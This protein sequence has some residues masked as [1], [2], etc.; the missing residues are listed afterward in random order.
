MGGIGILLVLL[1]L[2]IYIVKISSSSSGSGDTYRYTGPATPMPQPPEPDYILVA[3]KAFVV[4]EMSPTG[5]RALLSRLNVE[6]KEADEVVDIAQ[7]V[8]KAWYAREQDTDDAT[9]MEPVAVLQHIDDL[10]TYP[11]RKY[12]KPGE[13]Y[14]DFFRMLMGK[15]TYEDESAYELISYMAS[16]SS[17]LPPVRVSDR[18]QIFQ[19]SFG[20]F[21]GRFS[22][23]RFRTI[24]VNDQIVNSFPYL[25]TK[26]LM[27]LTTNEVI[28]W[29]GDT[30][31]NTEAE[32]KATRRDN[33]ELSF[34]ATDYAVNR[35]RYLNDTEI[36][37][38]I[39]A[40]AGEIREF[41]PQEHLRSLNIDTEAAKVPDLKGTERLSMYNFTARVVKM[42]EVSISKNNTAYILTLRMF[43][44]TD[45]QIYNIIDVFV[46]AEN[47]IS[48][49]MH[50]NI[51]VR[52]TFWLQGELVIN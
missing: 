23:A 35:Q 26:S 16:Y 42:K 1:R 19:M 10:V 11:V 5:V 4:S 30:A 33:T 25:A 24:K 50:Q 22:A 43:E 14:A 47:I 48:G 15:A 6:D 12:S 45:R 39:S 51:V 18:A 52:G 38:R 3:I 36:N 28:E 13:Q 46:N 44:N 34:F 9:G 41:N 40:F 29:E 31:I 49:E 21:G 2:V 8:A 20:G 32:I 27:P 37:V 17:F 7:K